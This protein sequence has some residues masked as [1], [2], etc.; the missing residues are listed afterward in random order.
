MRNLEHSKTQI[1]PVIL[2]NDPQENPNVLSS[3]ELSRAW[4][5]HA[6]RLLLIVRG[7]GEPADD[8]VQEAFVKLA[9][10]DHL[11]SEP[12]AWL[13]KV[14]RNELLQWWRSNGR[15]QQRDLDRHAN[16]PWF[17]LHDL[18]SNLDALEMTKALQA[19]P[20]DL[21]EPV[22]MHLWGGMSFEQIGEILDV[23]RSTAHR[24]YTEALNQLR[25]QF[26]FSL[27]S[28]SHEE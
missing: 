21:R 11:P 28:P 16:H 2:P 25:K 9:E 8:A 5:L 6:D 14:A 20:A 4:S 19:M 10:L 27:E 17:S 24:Q 13:V 12:M 26:A 3:D 1:Q 7:F 18:D 22:M 15:R 23:S